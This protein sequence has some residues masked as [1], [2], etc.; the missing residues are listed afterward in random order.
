MEWND[1]IFRYCERGSDPAFWAEP[2]NTA[3]NAAF[4]VAALLA[5]RELFRKPAGDRGLAE[6]SLVGLLVLM[7]IGSFLF[8]TFATRWATYADTVPI[9]IFMVGYLAYAL[10]R[11]LGFGWLW[12]GL[13][14]AGFIAA[15]KFAGEVQCGPGLLSVKAAAPAACLNGTLGYVPAFLA[16][17]AIGVALV[18][19]G[20]PARRHFLLASIVFLVSMTLRAVDL[21]T[22]DAT[23]LA[24]HVF[25]S[26][27]LW[28]I[29]NATT[30]YLLAT[31]AIRHGRS[32][33]SNTPGTKTPAADCTRTPGIA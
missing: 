4:I 25:G 16:M 12:V 3:S 1:Q 7:G 21:E 33:A 17:L 29:L 6:G 24:G 10:R 23:R 19:N 8:H 13:G 27:F 22:C 11:L 18:A 5:G 2:V 26:H 28:H 30:L 32:P 20:H 14:L 9:G 15:L 31:A